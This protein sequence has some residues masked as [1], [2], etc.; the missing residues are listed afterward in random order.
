METLAN[1]EDSDEL[2][3]YL[4]GN[5]SCFLLSADFFKKNQLFHTFSTSNSLDLDQDLIL[6]QTICKSY[7]QTTSSLLAR[8]EF[9]CTSILYG[10]IN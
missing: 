8:K 1:S 9:K 3:P 10:H 2:N 6:V 5:F 7:Q 4:L